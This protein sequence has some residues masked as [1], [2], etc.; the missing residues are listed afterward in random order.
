[1]KIIP[2]YIL[3]FV[4]AFTPTQKSCAE[5]WGNFKGQILYEG[6]APPIQKNKD[7]ELNAPICA[8]NA[9][10]PQSL[11]VDPKTNGIANCVI[12][13]SNKPKSIHPALSQSKKSFK[14]IDMQNCTI[15][16]H[17]TVLQ[18]N[19]TLK[20]I[21]SDPIPQAVRAN[22]VS[23]IGFNPML[24]PKD[25]KGVEF[26]FAKSEFIPMPVESDLYSWMHAY[27]FVV[28][29]PYYAVTN[30]Q[31]QFD[32]KN[33]PEGNHTFNIWQEKAGFLERKIKIKIESQKNTEK[34]LRYGADL[35]VE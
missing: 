13:L 19:Q 28:D 6:I 5:G 26:K 20:I 21:N 23:N 2:A 8:V 7:Y 25:M 16:P 15:V 33:L 1:M 22:L 3:V 10:L 24:A 30:S 34:R 9:V 31:G 14:K 4:L 32:I 35:F 11:E 27:C 17:I 29:H 12:W 18:T